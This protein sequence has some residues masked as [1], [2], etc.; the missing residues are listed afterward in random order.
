MSTW[1]DT[2]SP[3]VSGVMPPLASM[4]TCGNCALM[5]AAVSLSLSP[6]KLSSI[7]MSA[8]AVA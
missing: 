3:M 8:P 2:Y 1:G 5:V 6:E 4:S 7:T